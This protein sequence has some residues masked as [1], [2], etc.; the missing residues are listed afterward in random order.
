MC[1]DGGARIKAT[2]ETQERFETRTLLLLKFSLVVVGGW[3]QCDRKEVIVAL[4]LVSQTY[5]QM[6]FTLQ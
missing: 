1:L 2:R 6:V 3:H 5:H 4:M